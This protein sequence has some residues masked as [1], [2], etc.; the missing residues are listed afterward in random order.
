LLEALACGIPAAYL[1]SGGHP[2]L[3][4][5]GGLPFE[6]AEELPAV[7][8]QLVNELAERRAAIRLASLSDVADSYLEVLQS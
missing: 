3:V 4:G 2:E 5:G 1:A 6:R 8:E 7:L